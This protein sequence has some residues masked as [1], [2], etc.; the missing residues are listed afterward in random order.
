M[1]SSVIKIENLYKE[2]RVG[3]IGYGTLREDLES[4][5]AR[6]RGR[7]DP[8]SIIGQSYGKP[9]GPTD[10]I[11]ALND[12]NLEVKQGERLGIIGKNGAGKTTLLK[13]LA[14]IASPTKGKVMAKG[15]IASLIAVGTGFHYELTG[16][17]NVY[18]NG[19][20]LGLTKKEID[21]RFD[22]IVD[23]S[24]VEK[25]IDTPVKRYSSGMNVRLGFAVAA[26]LKPEILL[27]DEVL[28]V[29]DAEFQ[30]KAIGK[31]KDE[32]GDQGRTILFV[33][34]NMKAITKLCDSA[35][36]LESGKIV[37]LD[38]TKNVV[39]YY[40]KNS[41]NSATSTGMVD[42]TDTPQ[43]GNNSARIDRIQ[44]M[45]NG[46][47]KGVFDINE[48]IT[49]Q[50]DFTNFKERNMLCY[51]MHIYDE[52]ENFIFTSTNLPSLNFVKDPWFD[53]PYSAG[54]FR[55]QCH[56]SSNFL[57]DGEFLI[58]FCMNHNIN[59]NV[60]LLEP[61]MRF[62]VTDELNSIKELNQKLGGLVR[63]KTAW[64]TVKIN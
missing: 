19:S 31:M 32:S 6:I 30:K 39:E 60:A 16:R 52:N 8:N 28:A 9:I 63:K 42:L 29:G 4:W 18:L 51:Y 49:V 12:I 1:S 54:Q 64:K 2:Y 56:I 47:I 59:Q 23:F 33:S 7:P 21:N 62:Q 20:I 38:K 57:N 53:K 36:L 45:N 22:E 3:T 25:F 24:G 5:W 13:I 11:L 44:L 40:L 58:G 34:H 17:E 27:V 43:K 55:A 37:K 46:E 26:H 48:D 50:V 14:Q 41:T 35:I 10:H 15:R 61:M